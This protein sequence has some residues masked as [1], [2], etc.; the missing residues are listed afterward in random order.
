VSE[1]GKPKDYNFG[2][3]AV[4]TNKRDFVRPI[5]YR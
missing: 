1:A 4:T 2:E 3:L 5:V